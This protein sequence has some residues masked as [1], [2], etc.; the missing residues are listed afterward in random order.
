MYTL[1][2]L[3]DGESEREKRDSWTRDR[4]ECNKGSLFAHLIVYT[5]VSAHPRAL[6]H[7]ENEKRKMYYILAANNNDDDDS[8]S[9]RLPPHPS[10]APLLGGRGCVSFDLHP[11]DAIASHRVLLFCLHKQYTIFR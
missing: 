5:R 3:G 9:H 6:Q 7:T 1:L 10:A 2:V 4:R 11:M 8:L